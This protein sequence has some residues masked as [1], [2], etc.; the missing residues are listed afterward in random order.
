[1]STQ[2]VTRP[3]YLPA[4]PG[5][6]PLAAAASAGVGGRMFKAL[7]FKQSRFRVIDEEGTEKVLETFALPLAILAVNPAVSKTYYIKA[8]SPG[9]DPV[10]PDCWSDDG[11]TPDISSQHMQ[12]QSCAACK[13]NVWGSAVNPQNGKP[14]KACKDAKRMSVAIPGDPSKSAYS[15]RLSAMNMQSFAKF[16][17]ENVL[18]QGIRLDHIIV[19]ASFD[20][21]AE[22]PLLQFEVLRN[23]TLEEYQTYGA[24]RQ[25]DEAKGP[26]GLGEK[27]ITVDAPGQATAP[28]SPVQ[29]PTAPEP[30]KASQPV[31]HPD[32]ENAFSEPIPAQ[33]IAD[34]EDDA[35]LA[36]FVEAE[37]KKRGRPARSNVVVEAPAP[38]ADMEALLAKAFG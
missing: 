25:T 14:L 34:A 26:A 15:V 7:S 11:R 18:A 38:S 10:A 13:Q 12:A 2:I 4:M 33:A 37:K 9:D 20:S 27:V 1:M 24:M 30:E 29:L 16:V 3:D 22:F 8:Y 21:T 36:A 17:R 23:M 19:K 35:K 31:V 5:L 6:D 28:A 32:I